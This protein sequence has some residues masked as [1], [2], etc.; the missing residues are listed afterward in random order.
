MD[1]MYSGS[2]LSPVNHLVFGMSSVACKQHLLSCC[3]SS[4]M[5]GLGVG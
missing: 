3:H 2:N 4:Y 1:L 5:L